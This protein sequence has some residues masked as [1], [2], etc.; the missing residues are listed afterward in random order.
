MVE[1][2]FS[3]RKCYLR[4]DE[5]KVLVCNASGR[6]LDRPLSESGSFRDAAD[7]LS[8]LT[9][10]WKIPPMYVYPTDNEDDM[11]YF[12][13]EKRIAYTIPMSGMLSYT[14]ELDWLIFH[15]GQEVYN[16][17]DGKIWKLDF[18][19]VY[20]DERLPSSIRTLPN[21]SVVQYDEEWGVPKYPD[22]YFQKFENE[23]RNKNPE[24]EVKHTSALGFF[25]VASFVRQ[26]YTKVFPAVEIRFDEEYK[27]HR[28]VKLYD[29]GVWVEGPFYTDQLKNVA[30]LK[31]VAAKYQKQSWDALFPEGQD[32]IELS[33]EFFYEHTFAGHLF[34][35]PRSY[36]LPSTP[37]GH[38]IAW[39]NRYDDML[40]LRVNACQVRCP[41]EYKGRVFGKMGVN[42]KSIAQKFGIDHW[43]LKVV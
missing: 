4:V 14:E 32:V 3:G 5:D 23:L 37:N 9:T 11:D 24:V 31:E 20:H 21:H 42:I 35:T 41:D 38:T 40:I 13:A 1:L 10:R 2:K 7:A 36:G 16:V 39:E 12:E 15:R 33:K 17:L 34:S 27:T 18:R 19:A 29:M 30:T 6:S 22:E 26:G 8:W 43:R 28:V 25:K